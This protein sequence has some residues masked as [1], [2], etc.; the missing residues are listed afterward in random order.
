MSFQLK[1]LKFEVNYKF[2]V[3]A[4][5]GKTNKSNLHDD[6]KLATAVSK[7]PYLHDKTDKGFKE[8]DRKKNTWAKVEE[9]LGFDKGN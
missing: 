6:E 7:Y 2:G 9:E 1:I 3:V 8:R 5:M 4:N